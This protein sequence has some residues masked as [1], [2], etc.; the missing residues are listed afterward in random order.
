MLFAAVFVWNLIELVFLDGSYSGQINFL[1]LIAAYCSIVFLVH[2]YMMI[3]IEYGRPNWHFLPRL[4]TGLNVFLGFLVISLIF[5][6][7]FIAGYVPNGFS[8]TKIPGDSYWIFQT[9]LL[10]GLTFSISLLVAGKKNLPDNVQR[11]RC[12]VLLLSTIPA[13]SV[14]ALVVVLQAMGIEA[15]STLFQSLGFTAMLGMMVYAEENSRLFKLL[16]FIPFTRE[17]KLHKSILDQITN[18]IAIN[19]DPATQQSINLKRMMKEFEGLVVEHVIDYYDGNQ[20]L[21]ASALGVSEATI[22][23]RAR[24]ASKQ[25]EVRELDSMALAQ[26]SVR[27]TQ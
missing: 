3:A 11:Q 13:A 24:A 2:A 1:L 10:A 16:T 17:R 4:K 7:G 14:A 6:R 9:Y 22:S 26:D 23:R 27:I 8:V 25:A 5:D 12:L 19:D 20:K 18:C 15:T 21:A